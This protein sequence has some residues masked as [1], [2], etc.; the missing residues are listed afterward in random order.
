MQ[1]HRLC[2]WFHERQ[3]RRDRLFATLSAG[4]PDTISTRHEDRRVLRRFRDDE[5]K[6]L[7]PRYGL[8][9][10]GNDPR[11]IDV[12]VL[13]RFPIGRIRTNA[14]FRT[15]PGDR[16]RFLQGLHGGGAWIESDRPLRGLQTTSRASSATQAGSDRPRPLSL[17]PCQGEC[18]SPDRL[19]PAFRPPWSELAA[20]DIAHRGIAGVLVGAASDRGAPD[21][22]ES[23]KVAGSEPVAAYPPHANAL[24]RRL[25]R[26]R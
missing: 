6:P 18:N 7:K 26:R 8:L 19:H 13:S 20:S 3:I 16:W 4:A 5:L 14:R 24:L 22:S 2:Y 11:R 15:R 1:M 10:D 21:A 17:Q 23:P 12:A 9:I 25:A